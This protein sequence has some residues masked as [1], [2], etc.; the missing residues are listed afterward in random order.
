M[1]C[2]SLTASDFYQAKWL[3]CMPTYFI[4]D[5][6]SEPNINASARI[7]YLHVHFGVTTEFYIK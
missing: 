1:K 4:C 7:D 3:L 2:T 6:F 5:S